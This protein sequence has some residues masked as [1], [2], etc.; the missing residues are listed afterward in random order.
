MIAAIRALLPLPVP[1]ARIGDLLSRSLFPDAS[2]AVL[3]CGGNPKPEFDSV[4]LACLPAGLSR[5]RFGFA[6]SLRLLEVAGHPDFLLAVLLD[7]GDVLLGP[8]VMPPPGEPAADAAPGVALDVPLRF[9]DGV[10]P[11]FVAVEAGPP[12]RVGGVR[13]HRGGP[14]RGRERA[15]LERVAVLQDRSEEHT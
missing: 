2:L 4:N 12:D 14:D 13:V 9:G 1:S 11:G 6:W 7:P 3:P 10:Q 15:L 5:S 8:G